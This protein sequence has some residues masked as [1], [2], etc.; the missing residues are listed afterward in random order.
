MINLI[1]KIKDP[2][3]LA[4][5]LNENKNIFIDSLEQIDDFFIYTNR[6]IENGEAFIYNS[7][8]GRPVSLIMGYMNDKVDWTA[9]ISILMTIEG[10]GGKNTASKLINHF[11]Y[12]S[13]IKGMNVIKLTVLTENEVA[14]RFYKKHQYRI[15]EEKDN[16]Y[17]LIKNINR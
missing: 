7:E 8:Q 5:F 9:Y 1:T 15:L 16:R 4:S 13:K 17:V 6:F 12:E 10:Y 2:R 11:E 14:I 3:F